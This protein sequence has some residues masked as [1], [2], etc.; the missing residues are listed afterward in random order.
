MPKP[1]SGKKSAAAP[2]SLRTGDRRDRRCFKLPRFRADPF[3]RDPDAVLAV[4]S[5]QTGLTFKK[6]VRTI[7]VLYLSVPEPK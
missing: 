1:S 7:E 6:E 3:D 4:V 5:A 2:V